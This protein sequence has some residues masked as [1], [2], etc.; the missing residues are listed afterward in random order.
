MLDLIR[1]LNLE[2]AFDIMEYLAAHPD[3]NASTVARDLGVHIVTVQHVLDALESEGAV[4]ST[5]M[6]GTIGR[7][8]KAYRYRGGV[9]TI[10]LGALLADY[11][12]RMQHVRD[13]G[14][15]AVSYSYDIDHEVINAV[16]VGGRRGT[17]ITL[18]SRMGRL[19]WLVPPPDSKGI[20][21]Q[22]LAEKAGVPVLDA[23]QFIN[24]MRGKGIL[25]VVP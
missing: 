8:S 1:A 16:L 18:D 19:F 6:R 15:P 22:E 10:D 9:F 17:R 13:A 14:N 11:G 4:T 2:N 5:T 12:R 24:T 23:V 7:P 3:V 20:Q 21:I 25:E